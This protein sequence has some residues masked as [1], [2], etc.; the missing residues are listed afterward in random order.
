MKMADK[1][2]GALVGMHGTD[3]LGLISERDY[4]RKVIL[5][6]YSSKEL[7]IHEIMFSSAPT[8]DLKGPR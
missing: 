8:V 2:I 1:D 7:K 5:K 3:L 4:V 6:G